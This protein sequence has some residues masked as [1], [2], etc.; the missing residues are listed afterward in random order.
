MQG[1]HGTWSE[2]FAADEL[3]AAHTDTGSMNVLWKTF[4]P[5]TKKLG[6]FFLFAE[7]VLPFVNCSFAER[8]S[9]HCVS[10]EDQTY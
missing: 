5:P 10:T 3:T 9:W 8:L 2:S 4:I 1:K 6:N 7:I